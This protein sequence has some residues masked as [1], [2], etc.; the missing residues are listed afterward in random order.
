MLPS[1]GERRDVPHFDR[2]FHFE[3]A[4]ERAYFHP[5]G[6]M[7]AGELAD[8][9]THALEDFHDHGYLEAVLDITLVTGFE[10]PGSAYRRWLVRRWARVVMRQMAIAVVTL[11]K[12]IHPEK[13]GLVTAAEEGLRAHICTEVDEA[14]AWLDAFH[15]RHH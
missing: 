9:L 10:N 15:A 4:L 12:H 3:P 1:H 2:F 14:N 8:L 13:A 6:D 7:S 11:P 5:A